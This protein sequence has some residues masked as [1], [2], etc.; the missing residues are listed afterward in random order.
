MNQF[1]NKSYQKM[2]IFDQKRIMQVNQDIRHRIKQSNQ[3]Q[4]ISE[5]I[6]VKKSSILSCIENTIL[7]DSSK[8]F[9]SNFSGNYH[10]YTQMKFYK[11]IERS[12]I[13]ITNRLKS[14]KGYST[15]CNFIISVSIVSMDMYEQLLDLH[16]IFIQHKWAR[17]FL[18]TFSFCRS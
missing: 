3:G 11:V 5:S 17:Q 9:R 18:F 7:V 12:D 10:D 8:C 4:P 15:T 14:N 6:E 1:E 16:F 13:D 2:L